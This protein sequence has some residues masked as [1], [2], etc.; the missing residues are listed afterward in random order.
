MEEGWHIGVRVEEVRKYKFDFKSSVLYACR[1][2]S[3]DLYLVFHVKGKHGI[4]K[5]GLNL[6]S[7]VR[8]NYTEAIL[9]TVIKVFNMSVGIFISFNISILFPVIW[10]TFIEVSCKQSYMKM[11]KISKDFSNLYLSVFSLFKLY[12]IF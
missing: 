9:G 2:I 8:I 3:G 11:L 6:F 1:G 7:R 5:E 12:C 4:W 10:K